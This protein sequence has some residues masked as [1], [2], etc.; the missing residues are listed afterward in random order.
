MTWKEQKR[1]Y[2]PK[3]T[4]PN[5]N[6]EEK[7]V[8]QNKYNANTIYEW[9][10]DGMS[11]YIIL[12]LL[13]QMTMFS[14]VYK[15]QNQNGLISDHAI[16]NLLIVG[17]TGQLKGWWGHAYTKTQQE[18]ILKAIKKNTQPWTNDHTNIITQIKKQI[19]KLHCLHLANP[20]ALK[21]VD[22]DTFEIGYDGILKQ[23]KGGKKQIVQFTSRNWNPT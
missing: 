6:I 18:E 5:F 1:L 20:N 8:F 21:I 12:S 4:V 16:A 13:Q 19:V 15:T 22:I 9:K 2:Y 17:F 23:V 14:N 3:I 11:E 10:I 7:H